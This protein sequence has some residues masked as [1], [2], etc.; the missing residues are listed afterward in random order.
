MK[1]VNFMAIIAIAFGLTAMVTSCTN[2][3]AAGSDASLTATATD[4]T[5]ASNVSDEVVSSADE[6]VANFEYAGFKVKNKDSVIITVDRPDSTS[7]PKV[8]TID[9]GTTG[10]KGKRGNVL[11][12]KI[13]ITVSNRMIV[14]NS[15]RT[16][17]FSH[18]FINDNAV[19][20]SKTV[21]FMGLN[22]DANPYWTISAHDTITRVDGNVVIWN[23]ERTRT[24]IN[25]NNTPFFFWDDTYSLKGTSNGVNAKGKAYTMVITENNPLI[26]DGVFPY[27]TKGT[28]TITS[29]NKTVLVDYGDGTK[30]AKATATVNGVTKTFNLKK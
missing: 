2:D 20:G 10:F 9:F 30:D 3:A 26:I 25:N 27:F 4:E 13:I 5:Q 23:T 24:R 18:F 1:R 17:T 14:A 7:F 11:K 8:I 22:A 28:V 6:Y 21:T 15:T 16:I 29:E 19:K 12:G